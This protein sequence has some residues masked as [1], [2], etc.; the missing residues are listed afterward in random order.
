LKKNE[1]EKSLEITKLQFAHYKQHLTKTGWNNYTEESVPA[2]QKSLSRTCDLCN[3][4]L[5]LDNV[6]GACVHCHKQFRK[7]H[8]KEQ[9]NAYFREY[10]KSWSKV[11]LDKTHL[12]QKKYYEK[13][14]AKK[15]KNDKNYRLRFLMRA[16]L[17]KA[18]LA[19]NAIKSK[20]TIE[21][22]G[23]SIE[24]LRGYLEAKF[25]DGMTWENQGSW[26]VDHIMPLSSFDLTKEY[27]I[28]RACHYTNLQPLWAKENI[29]KGAK[30]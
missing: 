11:N 13:T 12:S 27:E 22:I 21:Y 29:R 2:L 7:E 8:C 26:H 3:K 18:L 24:K 19:Q 14:H 16:R 6:Y 17:R 20:K 4:T 28:H 30:I 9:A 23:C 25:T 5:N 15:W 10:F 1:I